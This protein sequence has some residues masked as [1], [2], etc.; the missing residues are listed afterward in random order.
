MT[1]RDTHDIKM[2]EQ[3]ENNMTQFLILGNGNSSENIIEDCLFDLPK[4]SVFHIYAYRTSEEGVCRVYDWLLDNKASYVAYHNKMA[5]Q[6]LINSSIKTV[7]SSVEEMIDVARGLKA[8]I[9]Y[10]WNEKNESQ[11]EKEVTKLIDAGIKVLDLTQGLTPFLIVDVKKVDSGTDL[12]KPITREEYEDMSLSS[13][14]QQATAQGVSE[15]NM[16]SKEKIIDELTKEVETS[17][18]V[19]VTKAS[20]KMFMVTE[21]KA[22]ELIKSLE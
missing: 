10:L 15:K 16:T 22:Q 18:I 4:D 1:S 13:L 12:L 3:E 6:L 19:V 20:S 11:C 7:E 9:L 5:P 8:T 21:K 14:K 17:T 2:Y